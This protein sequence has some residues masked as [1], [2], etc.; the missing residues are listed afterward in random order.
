MKKQKETP[1]SW[2]LFFIP[3]RMVVRE[4]I[5][6]IECY[7]ES[8]LLVKR[9]RV[10]VQLKTLIDQLPLVFSAGVVKINSHKDV[11]CFSDG[12]VDQSIC[13]RA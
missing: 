4:V 8:S 6:V 5:T 9:V 11:S 3:S 1:T 10:A 2:N 13:V 12:P 7:K